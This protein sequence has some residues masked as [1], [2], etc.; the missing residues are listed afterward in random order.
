[1]DFWAVHGILFC[2]SL[3]FF[4]RLTMLFTGIC[5]ASFAGILFWVG[6]VLAPRLTVA[7]LASWFYFHTNPILCVFVWLWAFAGESVEK[8]VSRKRTVIR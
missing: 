4:P 8:R 1:M 6:W 7:I 5:F 2:I 3:A